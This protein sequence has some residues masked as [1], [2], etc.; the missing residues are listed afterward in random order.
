MLQAVDRDIWV[1]EQPIRYFGLSIRTRMTVVRLTNQDLVVISPIRTEGALV[2]QLNEIGTVAHIIAPNLYHYMFANDFKA[3]YPEA[4]FWAAPGLAMKEPQLSIDCT[5]NAEKDW[6]FTELEFVFFDGFRTIGTRGFDP[7]NECIFFHA[8][9]RTLILTDAAFNFDES[10]PLPIRTIAKLGGGYKDLSPSRLE[11]IAT[12]DK[13]KVSQS[14]KAVLAWDFE[15]VIMAHGTIVEN[16]GKEKFQ[17][18]YERF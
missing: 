13:Q 11:K 17:S 14:V 12:T 1:A 15:R 16:N 6:P 2:N 3:I 5:L 18:S 4:T 7:L 10:F 8:K 9:S